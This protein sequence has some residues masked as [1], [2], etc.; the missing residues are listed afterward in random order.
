MNGKYIHLMKFDKSAWY[1][2]MGESLS[3]LL[4][5]ERKSV[6]IASVG[7]FILP[8]AKLGQIKVFYGYNDHPSAYMTW[9]YLTDESISLLRE[10]PLRILDIDDL[11]SGSNLVIF[12]ILSNLRSILPIMAHVRLLVRGNHDHF[13]GV[14]FEKSLGKIVLKKYQAVHL[15]QG[16]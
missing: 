14:R 1:L 16:S 13:Y 6:S 9:G 7:A 2:A 11:N 4:N 10:D 12:D 3:V 5:S 8:F 15:Q